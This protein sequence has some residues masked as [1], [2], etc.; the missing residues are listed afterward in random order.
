MENGFKINIYSDSLSSIQA[1]RSSK[2]KPNFIL[3]IKEK[4]SLARGY[5]G[6]SS[7]TEHADNTG[8]VT[9]DHFAKLATEISNGLEIA[10]PYSFHMK[11]IKRDLFNNWNLSWLD[12]ETGKRVRHFLP[13]PSY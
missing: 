4:L 9:A 6:L 2:S 3:K 13:S 12:F 1:L 11:N 8:N 7:V 10:V 5:V